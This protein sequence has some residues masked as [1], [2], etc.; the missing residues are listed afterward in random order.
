LEGVPSEEIRRIMQTEETGLDRIEGRKLRSFGHVMRMPE[1]RWP[2]IN[3]S[4]IPP[5][6][7][8]IRRRRRSWRDG[9]TEAMKKGGMWEEDAQDRILWRRGL[10]RRR[11]AI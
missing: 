1:E 11:T 4:W 3:H 7:R 5:G 8:K 10:E 2:A 9:V 6:R